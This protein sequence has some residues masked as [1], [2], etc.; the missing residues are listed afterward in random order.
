MNRKA[1]ILWSNLTSKLLAGASSLGAFLDREALTLVHIE[2]GLTGLKVCHQAEI[3]LPADGLEAIT[4]LVQEQITRWGLLACPVS[5]AANWPLGFLRRITLPRVAA[6]NLRQVVTYEIDR[7]L[8]LQAESLVFDFQVIQETE[9]D[10]QLALMALPKE[11]IESWLRICAAADL[12][13]IA[14]ELSPAAAANVFALYG[15]RRSSSW[16]LLQM[17]SRVFDLT[18]IQRHTLRDWHTGRGASGAEM[19]AKVAAEIDRLHR[20]GYAPGTIC[21]YGSGVEDGNGPDFSNYPSLSVIQE[22]HLGIKGLDPGSEKPGGILPALG[23]ALWGVGKVP[24][25]FNLLPEENRS[26]VRLTNLLITRVLLITL[27]SLYGVWLGS[28]FLHKK[29]ALYQVERQLAQLAPEVQQIEQQL[30]QSRLLRKQLQELYKPWE[31]SP[32]AL[33]LLKELTQII[34]V[35]TYLVHLSLTQECVEMSGISNSASDLISILEKSG[36]FTQTEF[37]SPIVTDATGAEN[38]KIKGKIK[39]QR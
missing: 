1:G 30:R 39:A 28:T 38:F 34:P 29:V 11:L 16:L 8:P 22:S 10:L 32:G 18:L 31:Q 37:A 4:P 9:T 35:H 2:K 12:R 3:R 17:D 7:F 6:E 25:S 24:I 23:A 20:E 13:P 36:W 14:V 19:R 15:R 26:E 27:I 33:P 5:L 21:V